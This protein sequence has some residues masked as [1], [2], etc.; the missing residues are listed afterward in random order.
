MTIQILTIAVSSHWG[1]WN[2]EPWTV[3]VFYHQTYGFLKWNIWFVFN[4]S[5]RFS[6]KIGFETACSPRK[7]PAKWSENTASASRPRHAAGYPPPGNGKG[8]AVV[9]LWNKL[10]IS[11]SSRWMRVTRVFRACG[12]TQVLYTKKSIWNWHWTRYSMVV[13]ES[14]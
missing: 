11:E 8:D 14:Q 6:L 5:Y 1:H 2:S 4:E 13:W 12:A 9:G 10:A 3:C 7:C